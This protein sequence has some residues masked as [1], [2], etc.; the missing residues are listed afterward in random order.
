MYPIQLGPA[1]RDVNIDDSTA[2]ALLQMATGTALKGI[3]SMLWMY[4]ETDDPVGNAEGAKIMPLINAVG[5]LLTGFDRSYDIAVQ[6]ATNVYPGDEECRTSVGHAKF[7]EQLANTVIDIGLLNSAV[8]SAINGKILAP[9]MDGLELAL[10]YD[11]NQCTAGF[12]VDAMTLILETNVNDCMPLLHL[13][14]N[15]VP[16]VDFASYASCM[17]SSLVWAEGIQTLDSCL[18]ENDCIQFNT[19]LMVQDEPL[20]NCVLENGYM[21]SLFGL[22]ESLIRLL[23]LVI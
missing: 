9:D 4:A 5:N 10:C 7:H 15:A 17:F 8:N 11:K 19:Q 14:P 12:N 23:L 22:A 13:D 6:E 2:T 18:G 16:M 21:V 20:L 1:L 3:Y